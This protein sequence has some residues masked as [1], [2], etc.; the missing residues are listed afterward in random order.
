[1]NH[2]TLYLVGCGKNKRPER[3]PAAD[4]YYGELFKKASRLAMAR[5][6]PAGNWR[7]L[8][9]KHGVVEPLHPLDPY[10]LTLGD[11]NRTELDN[12]RTAIAGQLTELVCPGDVVIILAGAKYRVGL[13]DLFDGLGVTAF[14][15]MVG[16]GIGQQL[17][18][19]TRQL[20]TH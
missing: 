20:A 7:I 6:H 9:A 4:L 19:L 12:W 11:L 17:G 14:A 13:G 18:W 5:C 8:S 16:L 15:P 10:D 3:K 1:M 2:Q